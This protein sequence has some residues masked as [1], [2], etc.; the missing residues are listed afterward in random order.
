VKP[1]APSLRSGVGDLIRKL[2]RSRFLRFLV[3]GGINTVFGYGVFAALILLGVWYPV[4]GL[5]STVL[6][7]LFNFV[8]TG[9][10]VFGNRDRSLVLRFSLIYGIGYIVGMAALRL[11]NAL[12]IPILVA[13]AALILPMAAFSFTLQRLL[14]FS[15]ER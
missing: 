9:T 3:V 10:F 7:V 15:R 14:V 4:A 2:S 6:G 13:S 1:K 11:T 12:E 5:V 8:T